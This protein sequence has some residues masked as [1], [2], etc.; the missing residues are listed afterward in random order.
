MNRAD[1]RK[2]SNR[3]RRRYDDVQDYSGHCA[4]GMRFASTAGG[5]EPDDLRDVYFCREYKEDA[6]DAEEA[7]E[8]A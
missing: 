7:W 3:V 8:G 5:S 2:C 1:C 6:E 4:F